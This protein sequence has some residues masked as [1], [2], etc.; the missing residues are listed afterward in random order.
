MEGPTDVGHAHDWSRLGETSARTW[1][2]L[3]RS[4]PWNTHAVNAR[5]QM[6]RTPQSFHAKEPMRIATCTLRDT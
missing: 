4:R 2:S 5:L 3:R 1:R 6:D